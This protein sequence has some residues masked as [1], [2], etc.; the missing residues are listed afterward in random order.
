MFGENGWLRVSFW[1]V[2]CGSSAIESRTRS[3][4]SP[5]ESPVAIISVLASSFS[6]WHPSSLSY[7]NEYLVTDSGGNV[8]DLVVARNCCMARM[9]PGEAEFTGMVSSLSCSFT[10][11]TFSP[12]LSL[13]LWSEN[14]PHLFFIPLISFLVIFFASQFFL[15]STPVGSNELLGV[16]QN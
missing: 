4:E 10:S 7:I 6:P 3:Q 8:S 11:S 14:V 2:E 1:L 12:S 9:L 13:Y 15:T 16:N 5:L